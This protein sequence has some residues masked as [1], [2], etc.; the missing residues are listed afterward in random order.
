MST[1]TIKSVSSKRINLQNSTTNY[2]HQQLF[3]SGYYI[4]S[5][6]GS[7]QQETPK[8]NQYVKLQIQQSNLTNTQLTKP[9]KIKPTQSPRNQTYQTIS[10][11]MNYYHNQPFKSTHYRRTTTPTKHPATP[12]LLIHTTIKPKSRNLSHARTPET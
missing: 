10:K 4:P 2:L 1:V 9:S 11:L 5:Q 12:K 8:V 3:F 6:L 7:I